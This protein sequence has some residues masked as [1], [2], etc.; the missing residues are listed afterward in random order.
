VQPD[1]SDLLG[2]PSSRQYFER[3]VENWVDAN[4]AA[5]P[6]MPVETI[7]ARVL[8]LYSVDNIR[9]ANYQSS[10]NMFLRLD[11]D[12]M[13]R[14]PSLLTA[15]IMSAATDVYSYVFAA[16]PYE[17]DPLVSLDLRSTDDDSSEGRAGYGSD[18]RN[19][20][21]LLCGQECFDLAVAGQ[22]SDLTL[23][24][25]GYL[26]SLQGNGPDGGVVVDGNTYTWNKVGANIS[27]PR[28]QTL[29]D[30]NTLVFDIPYLQTDSTALFS[31]SDTDLFNLA[32][33]SDS[34][35][36]QE[37]RCAYWWSLFEMVGT[38]PDITIPEA[39]G[40]PAIPVVQ[41][42]ASPAAAAPTGGAAGDGG[43][44]TV[45]V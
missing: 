42:S 44:P 21:S 13:Y 8:E 35:P 20:R 26:K 12:A 14:C 40:E 18:R 6:Q 34:L 7:L 3:R 38:L 22:L 5:F 17:E 2:V 11:S 45:L 43:A 19:L 10:A 41:P 33:D 31:E 36:S 25:V 4:F 32:N 29:A 39:A 23:L 15:Q 9:L 37:E 24:E 30:L 16:G 27:T 1:V 28:P